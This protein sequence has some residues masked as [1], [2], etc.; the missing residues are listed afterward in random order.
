[1]RRLIAALLVLASIAPACAYWQSRAQDAIAAAG[2][3][4]EATNFLARTSGLDG[5]H[6]TA[7]TTMICGLVTDGVFSQLDAL[8]VFATDTTTNAQLSLV[9]ATY[10]ASLTGA[11]TFAA[12]AGYTTSV[13]NY[14]NSNFNP[15]TATTPKFVQN[16]GSASAWSNTAADGGNTF[17]V[18]Y[19]SGAT[20]A[21]YVSPR[22]GDTFY[23]G[24]NDSSSFLSVSNVTGLGFYAAN[25]S[26]SN[27]QQNYKNGSSVATNS[28]A[29][30]SVV[31]STL[32]W[33]SGW[34]G[35]VMAGS[36]GQSLSATDHLNLC[37]RVSAFL[38]TIAG[39]S[40]VC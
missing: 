21:T 25:R 4:T 16:S 7:Y 30:A 29:S 19:A 17:V 31:N 1:M 22:N 2:G 20:G 40:S 12:N 5:T 28:S 23:G 13:G 24:V 3:C 35:Q 9:S 15:S 27:A 6:T 11:P 18:G 8:Y 10:N 36:I 14:V 32:T 26:A 39:V 34:P 38:V 33:G 37:K